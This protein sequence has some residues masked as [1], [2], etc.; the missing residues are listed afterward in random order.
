MNL[1]A[2]NLLWQRRYRGVLP[3]ATGS[4]SNEGQ[5]IAVRPDALEA[6]TYQVLAISADGEARELAA[7]SVETVRRFCVTADA[8]VLLGLTEDDLYIFRQG[9]KTRFA[10]ERRVTYADA[11]LSPSGAFACAFSDMMFASHTLALVD[12]NGRL[13]WTKDMPAPINRAAIS[14]DGERIAAGREDGTI[15]LLD[16]VRLPIWEYLQAEP[17]TALALALDEPVCAVGTQGGSVFLTDAEGAL[18]WRAAPGYPVLGVALDEQVRWVAAAAGDQVIG[19]LACFSADGTLVW[20]FDLPGRPTGVALSPN[21]RFL[22]VSLADGNLLTFAVDFS[23]QGAPAAE[24]PVEAAREAV[25]AGDLEAA[26][27]HLLHALALDSAHLD[28]CRQLSE[29]EARRVAELRTH[30]EDHAREGQ[31]A[32]ALACLTHAQ[33]TAPLD[34]ELFRQRRAVHAQAVAHWRSTAGERAAAGDAQAALD[35]WHTLLSLEPTNQEARQQ[36]AAV[37]R[38][39]GRQ[40]MARGDALRQS[41]E[42]DAAIDTWQRAL[43]ISPDSDIEARLHAAEIERCLAIGIQYYRAQRFPEAAFQFRKVLALDPHHEEAIRYLGYTQGQ[44]P[45]SLIPNRFTRLE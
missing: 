30:A 38:L 1:Q 25:A 41:G 34:E 39:Q 16:R 27:Q 8:S 4:L 2:V 12:P 28:A 22:A 26:R 10:P 11:D 17:V 21:G 18:R 3:L 24:G 5:L 40:L 23:A 15:L 14:A 13:V 35:A 31:Y 45:D 7:V 43:A 37:Q 9:R 33:Q 36:L 44:Q 32:E 42:L 29:V 19:L 6:R 20:E